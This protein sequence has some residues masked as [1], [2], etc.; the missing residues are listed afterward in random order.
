MKIDLEDITQKILNP[1][2]VTDKDLY[3]AM[4]TI[5]KISSR[6]SDLLIATAKSVEKSLTEIE[7]ISDR[8]YEIESKLAEIASSY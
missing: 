4:S 3:K 8:I 2:A 6:Q 1:E 5:A 7:E